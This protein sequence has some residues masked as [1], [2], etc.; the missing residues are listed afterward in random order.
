MSMET[1]P[2]SIKVFFARKKVYVNKVTP[3]C[4]D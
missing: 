2:T 1:L 4:V 3:A